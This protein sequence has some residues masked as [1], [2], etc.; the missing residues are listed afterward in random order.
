MS[1]G[2]VIHL[3]LLLKNKYASN[4]KKY[5]DFIS[6]FLTGSDTTIV[7]QCLP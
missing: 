1:S 5:K 3:L 7:G 6:H 4:R 2:S